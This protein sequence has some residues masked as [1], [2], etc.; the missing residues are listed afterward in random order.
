MPRKLAAGE[1]S[2]AGEGVYRILLNVSSQVESLRLED[3]HHLIPLHGEYFRRAWSAGW[4]G[5]E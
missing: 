4:A 5:L 3:S 2:L 1:F